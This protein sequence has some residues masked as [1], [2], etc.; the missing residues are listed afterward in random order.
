MLPIAVIITALAA[1]ACYMGD[2]ATT[3]MFAVVGMSIAIGSLLTKNKL[4]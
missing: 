4:P 2:R 1:V 3:V